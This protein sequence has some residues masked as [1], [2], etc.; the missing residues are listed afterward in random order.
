MDWVEPQLQG[1]QL[2]DIELGEN[3]LAFGF[4]KNGPLCLAFDLSSN[5]PLPLLFSKIPFHS[6]ATKPL[7]LFL[8]SHASGKRVLQIELAETLGRVLRIQLGEESRRCEIEIRLIPRSV[9][10]IAHSDDKKISLHK[11]QELKAQEPMVFEESKE[12]KI[13][14]EQISTEWL[15]QR[16]SS[17]S[18]KVNLQGQMSDEDK[19][20]VQRDKNIKKKQAAQAALIESL[21]SDE[22][23]HW[24]QAGEWLKA[25]QLNNLPEE[26]KKYINPDEGLAW[27]IEHA[28][29]KS[30]SLK[31]KK[32][33]T[34]NR[35]EVLEKEIADLKSMTFKDFQKSKSQMTGKPL[36]EKAKARGRKLQLADHI[37]VI[38]GKN[39]ADNLAILRKANSWDYWLHL[40]DYPGAHAIIHRPKQRALTNQEVREAAKWFI[41]ES[42]KNKASEG[43]E[44]ALLMT[45]CRY[46]KP[47]KGDKLGR[48][49]YANE[50]I[51]NIK[52]H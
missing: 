38:I 10:V 20:L 12:S 42:L 2:Q 35:I 46:V 21:K 15:A 41:K 49:N 4:W 48:V 32:L 19:W 25:Y 8:K 16:R 17:K 44:Y 23:D 45:E 11:V 26:F 39:A 34:Q 1:A 33:G 43:Q 22:A 52:F 50:K 7:G 31:Q 5:S 51:L 47:I 28:F 37:D 30:K 24:A 29:K 27:N 3:W 14:F 36:M 6:K 13:D 40:R 9:N 18:S